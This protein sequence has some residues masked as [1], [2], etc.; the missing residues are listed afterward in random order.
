MSR[1]SDREPEPR[2]EEEIR[3]KA[4]PLRENGRDRDFIVHLDRLRRELFRATLLRSE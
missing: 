3:L 4:T 2:G 1:M